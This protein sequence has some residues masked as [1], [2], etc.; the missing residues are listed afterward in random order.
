MLSKLSLVVVRIVHNS[1]AVE[2]VPR[3]MSEGSC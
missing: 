3:I 1:M 2:S